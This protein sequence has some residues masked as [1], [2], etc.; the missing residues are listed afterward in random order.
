L[1]A[2]FDVVHGR[3]RQPQEFPAFTGMIGRQSL[4]DIPADLRRRVLKLTSQPA[5]EVQG[6]ASGESPDI[7]LKLIGQPTG[8][9]TFG[10]M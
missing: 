6:L 10:R 7:R 5:I 1:Q 8:R 4:L 9:E 3:T 2:G